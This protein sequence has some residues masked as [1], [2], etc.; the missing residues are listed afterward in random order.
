MTSLRDLPSV[1]KLLQQADSLI[2]E[3]GR[4]LTLDAFRTVLE[5]IRTRFKSKPEAGLPADEEILAQVE[6]QLARW[7]ASTLMP[8][9]NATGVILHTNLGRAPLS[10]ATIQAMK[11]V[12]ENLFHA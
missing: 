8:V 4:P 11:D 1:E 2:E 5:E 12:S 10:P 3:Y 9:I 6:S 7:T